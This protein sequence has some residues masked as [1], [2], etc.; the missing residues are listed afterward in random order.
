MAFPVFSTEKGQN[1]NARPYKMGKRK[2][3]HEPSRTVRWWCD[4]HGFVGILSPAA[5]FSVCPFPCFRRGGHACGGAWA[6][7][8]MNLRFSTPRRHSPVY[9]L[10]TRSKNFPFLFYF[11]PISSPLPPFPSSVP[12]TTSLISIP[13][14]TAALFFCPLLVSP[15]LPDGLLL[16]CSLYPVCNSDSCMPA[17]IDKKHRTL[18]LQSA[19]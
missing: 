8:N 16:C 3:R 4:G 13:S 9:C 12:P 19:A 17:D 6:W 10:A 7:D 15:S 1:K 2:K 14:L 5:A 11:L 18:V